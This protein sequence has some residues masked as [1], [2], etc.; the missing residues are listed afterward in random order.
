MQALMLLI[1]TIILI[2]CTD[3][4]Q[5]IQGSQFPKGDSD[6]GQQ[7]KVLAHGSFA[8][9][10]NFSLFIEEGQK[11][12]SFD[13]TPAELNGI[14]E[15][16][17]LLYQGFKSGKEFEKLKFMDIS[18]LIAPEIFLQFKTQLEFETSSSIRKI[19][20]IQFT[21]VMVMAD[22][23]I[24]IQKFEL[25]EILSQ[26]FEINTIG[27]SR[28]LSK[29]I[30]SLKIPIEGLQLEH[31][32]SQPFFQI[33]LAI[34]DFQVF[35]SDGTSLT[36]DGQSRERKI[37]DNDELKDKI[38]YFVGK[39]EV[40]FK[41]DSPAGEFQ[42]D[43]LKEF[44]WL[45]VEL[46]GEFKEIVV[47]EPRVLVFNSEVSNCNFAAG[48][49][50][51]ICHYEKGLCGIRLK[52]FLGLQKSAIN[53]ENYDFLS[54]FEFFLGNS[55]ISR[56]ELLK[57]WNFRQYAKGE[58]LRLVLQTPDEVQGVNTLTIKS[59]IPPSWHSKDYGMIDFEDCDHRF[60]L[61]YFRFLNFDPS[62]QS[63]GTLDGPFLSGTSKLY[64][65]LQ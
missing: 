17:N 20:N 28:H 51:A 22:G 6:T 24:D 39:P 63:K 59:V 30:L 14:Q 42:I 57:R 53:W 41:Q 50:P 60:K 4:P 12:I 49:H 19:Y 1:L 52:E 33:Y 64:Q 61:D 47:S 5:K 45:E 32:F 7:D 2:S 29:E 15:L 46:Q 13:L 48:N 3:T 26:K 37:E 38:P 11:T 40:I 44:Q 62:P 65:E 54:K 25:D 58:R 8:P 43:G 31:L 18:D 56:H 21:I 36:L 34:T 9:V 27:N 55:K 23:T 10:G 16:K 35:K